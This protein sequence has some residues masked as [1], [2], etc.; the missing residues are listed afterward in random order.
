METLRAPKPKV[1]FYDIEC[2]TADCHA[3]MRCR[4]G[5]LDYVESQDRGH[6]GDTPTWIMECPHCRNSTYVADLAK[7]AVRN[8]ERT[9]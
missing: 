6:P 5:D 9:S 3:L 1:E 8:E 4:K 7:R 2:S